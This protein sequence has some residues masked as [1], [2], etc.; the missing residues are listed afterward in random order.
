MISEEMEIIKDQMDTL[1]LKSTI[2]N[3]IFATEGSMVDLH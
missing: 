1:E 3:E 2:T